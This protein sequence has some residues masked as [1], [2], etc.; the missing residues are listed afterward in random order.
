MSARTLSSFS[1]EGGVTVVTGGARGL[2]MVMGYACVQSGS[3][4]AIVDLNGEEAKE[5]AKAL[6]EQYKK[7]NP[8]E[9]R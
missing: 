1:L 7:E 3:D 6:T 8:N 5:T 4:L 9:T 2:G